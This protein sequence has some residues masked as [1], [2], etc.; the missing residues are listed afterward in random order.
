MNFSLPDLR[1][2]PTLHVVLPI[3]PLRSHP[4]GARPKVSDSNDLAIQSTGVVSRRTAPDSAARQ[5]GLARHRDHAVEGLD[6][7]PCR[8]RVVAR[9]AAKCQLFRTFDHPLVPSGEKGRPL[10]PVGGV[11]TEV[12]KSVL[13]PLGHL[14]RLDHANLVARAERN[15]R[16]LEEQ[17]ENLQQEG[18][19]DYELRECADKV[20]E[21][22]GVSERV[23]VTAADLASREYSSLDECVAGFRDVALRVVGRTGKHGCGELLV[24]TEKETAEDLRASSESEHRSNA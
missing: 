8:I 18:P 7:E 22:T 19:I 24:M 9:P 15:I 20:G 11:E 10:H 6:K 21:R 4:R 12:R 23:V 1:V 16:I 3:S 17:T 2:Q 14:V 13:H 5:R